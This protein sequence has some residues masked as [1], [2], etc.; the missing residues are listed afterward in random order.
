MSNQRNLLLTRKGTVSSNAQRFC[1]HL[2][3]PGI[4]FLLNFYSYAK[5]IKFEILPKFLISNNPQLSDRKYIVHTQEPL[6]IAEIFEMDGD[7]EP[8]PELLKKFKIGS[9][10]K[11]IHGKYYIIGVIKIENFN[12]NVNVLSKIMSCCGDW[13]FEL[14]KDSKL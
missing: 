10:T 1:I 4:P 12:L 7:I 14:V 13:L 2:L 6:F 11:R 9:R 5:A 3:A 8:L